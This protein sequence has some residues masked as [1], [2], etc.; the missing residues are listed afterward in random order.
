MG[1]FQHSMPQIS[2]PEQNIINFSVCCNCYASLYY[3]TEQ[4]FLEILEDFPHVLILELHWSNSLPYHPVRTLLEY[5]EEKYRTHS[6]LVAVATWHQSYPPIR[7]RF[8]SFFSTAGDLNTKLITRLTAQ[9]HFHDVFLVNAYEACIPTTQQFIRDEESTE[10][11]INL[12]SEYL[13][14][15]K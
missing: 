8:Q 1:V 4:S 3:S 6:S 2:S 14:M 10:E 13:L 12:R 5:L 15:Q 7:A 11:E 9:K